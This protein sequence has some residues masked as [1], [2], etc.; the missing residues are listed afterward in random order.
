MRYKFVAALFL[1]TLPSVPAHAGVEGLTQV[2]QAR[3]IG[4]DAHLRN[5]HDAMSGVHLV[6]SP[7]YKLE[8]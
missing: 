8:T 4:I 6:A 1:A 2:Q 7:V 3:F 5:T